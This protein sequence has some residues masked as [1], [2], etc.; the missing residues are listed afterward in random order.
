MGEQ[1]AAVVFLDRCLT[2]ASPRGNDP[3]DSFQQ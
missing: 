3:A 2:P 1:P